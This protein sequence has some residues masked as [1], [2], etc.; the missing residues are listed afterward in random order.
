MS[1]S[2]SKRSRGEG[3][4]PS[5]KPKVDLLPDPLSLASEAKQTKSAFRALNALELFEQD[6]RRLQKLSEDQKLSWAIIKYGWSTVNTIGRCLASLPCSL[7]EAR[8]MKFV[9]MACTDLVGRA[10]LNAMVTFLSEQCPNFL[11]S[12][13]TDEVISL[14]PPVAECIECGHRLVSYHTCDVTVYS[15]KGVKSVSKVTLRCQQ[16]GL[17]YGYSQFGNKHEVGFRFYP[18]IQLMVEATD[19]VFVERRMLELH[20][21]LA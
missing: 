6:G 5:K 8:R 7:T 9:E 12:L 3:P 18:Q 13:A 20:C 21:S 16:C 19:T 10:A 15:L 4:A 11:S 2:K 1:A 17:L 14:A